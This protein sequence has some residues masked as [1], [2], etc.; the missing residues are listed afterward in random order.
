MKATL[1]ASVFAVIATALA[2]VQYNTTQELQRQL[3]ESENRGAT[4]KQQLQAQTEANARL[5]DTFEQQIN[6]LQENLQSSSR[7]LVILSESLQETREMLN[8][9]APV[10]AEPAAAP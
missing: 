9:I 8:A 7:Q 1:A 4:L 5:Q 2:L 3:L 10:A 6:T